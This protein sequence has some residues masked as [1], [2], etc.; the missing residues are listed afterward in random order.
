MF[1]LRRAISAVILS[2]VITSPV[3]AIAPGDRVENFRLLD[4][5]G[6]SHLLSY[7]SDQRAIVLMS[8]GNGCPI[9]RKAMPELRALRDRFQ[10]EGVVFL[11]LDSNLQDNRAAVAAEAAEY[12]IDLPVLLDA[13]QL[14]GEALGV[15][16]TGE[17]YLIDPKTWHLNYR[18][19]IDDRLNYGAQRE[20]ARQH[21]LAD[22]LVATLAGKPVAQPR[23]DA[24]G[25][26]VNFP[27]RAADH[28]SISYDQTIAPLLLEKCVACHRP[29]GVAPWAMTSY[30]QV[31][32]FAPMMREVL[33]TKRMPPWQA[34][35]HYGD[36]IGDRSI[37]TEQLKTLVHWIEAG[38]PR[39][40]GGDPLA[41]TKH[42]WSE[43]T[44]GKPDLII[45]T[46][47]YKVPAVGAVTYQ[48]PRV[49]N[50]LGRDVWIRGIEI[51]PGRRD[52]V[53]HVLAGL[54]D[55]R[56]AQFPGS[57][58]E[59][60]GYAPGKNAA[61]YPADTGILLRKEADFR[62]QMHYTPNGKAVTDVT[63][64]G[65][66]LSEQAP[67]HE[68][69]M[70]LIM[71]TALAIPAGAKDYSETLSHV[72]DRD[73][74]LYSLLPH[75]HLRGK[76]AKYT[77]FYPSGGS[78]VLLSVPNYDFNWQPTYFLKNPK[79]I[80]RGTKLVLDMHW[81]NSA[82]N[83]L[84]PDPDR[85]VRWGDQTWEEMNVGWLRYRDAEPEDQ[86]AANQ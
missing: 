7:Y 17:V 40:S 43:W 22:A 85:V 60:G 14:V 80:P 79:R 11:L 45:E 38:A 37:S 46:P 30:E 83:P 8:F 57:V 26:L 15:E 63:R 10:G 32:G 18:G 42:V 64:V 72:F 47:P 55:P 16:R 12:G 44:M 77:A 28:K 51:L 50:P 36:F 84:N 49:A 48:Y 86:H 5:L 1:F 34:D 2:V 74:M 19:P 82:Q 29:G 58:G 54:E 53:H 52:V 62:F 61:P 78:E 67:R 4:H 9:V 35:P 59:L 31:R 69:K 21:F 41:D 13:G 27:E 71:N 24:P 25:C 75:A 39:G 76:A 81:D 20:Q 6:A 66:Y 56:R 23:V 73:V 65:L 33:R 3:L 68:L 70:T